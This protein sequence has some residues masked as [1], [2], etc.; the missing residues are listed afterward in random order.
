MSRRLSGSIALTKLKSVITE[1]KGKSGMI[2]GLFIPLDINYLIVLEDKDGN[3]AV[4]LPV[5]VGVN[6]DEDNYG[7]IGFI[8]QSVDSK[9]YKAANEEQKEVFK[10]LPFL[11]NLKEFNKTVS[12]N[13]SAPAAAAEDDLPF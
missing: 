7:Q 6:D 13:D 10:K 2:K 5:T 3:T 1:R 9:I 12:T 4:Y 8:A 11:G